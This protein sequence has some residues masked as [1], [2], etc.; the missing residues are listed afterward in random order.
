MGF[1]FEYG[2]RDQMFICLVVVDGAAPHTAG[3]A[4]K[5]NKGGV[6]AAAVAV[7]TGVT[8]VASGAR[9]LCVGE[10]NTDGRVARL[11]PL[12]V[13]QLDVVALGT[14]PTR[15]DDVADLLVGGGHHAAVLVKRICGGREL[16]LKLR[17]AQV[18]RQAKVGQLAQTSEQHII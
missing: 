9:T 18:L 10:R 8:G 14:L 4:V 12:T 13:G 16:A 11:I 17:E 3:K 5:R 1:G 7:A 15:V 6:V 2:T